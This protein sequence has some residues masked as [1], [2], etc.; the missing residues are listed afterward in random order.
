MGWGPKGMRLV[1]F[2]SFEDPTCHSSLSLLNC[3]SIST[4]VTMEVLQSKVMM[5]SNQIAEIVPRWLEE[6]QKYI[7]RSE[8][9]THLTFD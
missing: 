4:R 3:W 8:H 5:F 7:L 6:N 1:L 2:C 9:A